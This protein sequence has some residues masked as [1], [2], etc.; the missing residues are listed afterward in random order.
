MELVKK[1]DVLLENEISSNKAMGSVTLV[2]FII[3]A[4]I[5]ILSEFEVFEIYDSTESRITN[6]VTLVILCISFSVGK[7]FGY[8]KRWIK[9]MQMTSMILALA[10]IDV[11]YTYNVT[12]IVVIPIVLSSRYF[13]EKFTLVTLGNTF[14]IFLASKSIGAYVG[15]IDLNCVEVSAGTKFNIVSDTWLYQV[16]E[17]GSIA[18]DRENYLFNVLFYGYAIE[19]MFVLIVAASCVIIAFQGKKLIRR[20]KEMTEHTVRVDTELDLASKLQMDMV[21]NSFP[22]F[23]EHDE[24]DLYASMTPAKEVGGDF[25]DYFMI[26]EDHLYIIMADV[27]GKGIPAAMFMMLAKGT[28]A[29]QVMKSRSPGQALKDANEELCKNKKNSLFVTVWLGILTIST[30]KLVAANAGHEFPIIKHAD[31][32]FEFLKDKHGFVLGGR[33]GMKYP[34]YELELEPGSKLFLYTDGVPEANN[35]AEEQFGNDRLIETIN[36]IDD[37]TPKDVLDGVR[38]GVDEFI[39]KAEQFDDLTMLCLEYKGH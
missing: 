21:P 8:Q 12:I 9:Y 13:S 6:T 4:F 23:P 31:G 38:R 19:M 33:E 25:Y 35:E 39:G 10:I 3:L 16:F 27:S 29:N 26:D 14:F 36:S 5:W 32:V 28:L 1:N 2:T 11:I 17:N 30:G 20:Q 22:A 34:E 18:F 7:Y 24:F 15:A 37:S